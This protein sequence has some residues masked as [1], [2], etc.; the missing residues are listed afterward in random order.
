MAHHENKK[1]IDACIR[2]AQEC[3]HCAEAC[4]GEENVGMMAGCIRLDKDC[5]AMC[6]TTAA[7]MS[8]GSTFAEEICRVC[9]EIC[10]ACAAECRQHKVDHCQRCAKACAECADQ[11]RQMAGVAA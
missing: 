10:E 4:L 8:R 11:C 5:A 1:C 6:W 3:E 7:F 2:C 9:A